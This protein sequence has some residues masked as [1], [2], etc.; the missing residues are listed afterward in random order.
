MLRG[1]TFGGGARWRP[2]DGGGHPVVAGGPAPAPLAGPSWQSAQMGVGGLSGLDAD[3][4][5][6][7]LGTVGTGDDGA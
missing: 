5:V 2:L 7:G 1:L 6:D 3:P 4:A